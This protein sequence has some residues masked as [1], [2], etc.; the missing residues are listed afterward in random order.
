MGT[1][2]L[3][4]FPIGMVPLSIALGDRVWYLLKR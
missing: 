4:V 2:P 3:W 1:W